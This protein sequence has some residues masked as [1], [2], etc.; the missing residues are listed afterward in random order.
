MI[1]RAL[2][3]NNDLII[4]SG[5]LKI[6]EDAAETLQH[7]RTRL[8][9]YLGEWFLDLQSGTPYYQEIFIKPANLASIESIFKLRILNTPGVEKL[10]EFAMDYE[11]GSSRLLTINFSAET[12]YGTIDS[13]KVT[14]NA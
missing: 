1:G 3:S 7:L 12:I 2:D 5:R 13:E 14:I 9:F 4:E 10:T 6:V 11:G 8:Q